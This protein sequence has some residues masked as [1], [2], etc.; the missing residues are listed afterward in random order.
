LTLEDRLD[1]YENE[2]KSFLDNLEKTVEAGDY[3]QADLKRIVSTQNNFIKLLYDAVV[4]AHESD[5]PSHFSSEI[6]KVK[7]IME[8]FQNE[9]SS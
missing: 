8:E 2:F 3:D 5:Y 1:E 9:E 4:Y 7:Q 6:K